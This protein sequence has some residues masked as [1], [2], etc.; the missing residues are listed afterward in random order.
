VFPPGA[1]RCF[2]LTGAPIRWMLLASMDPVPD[3]TRPQDRRPRRRRGPWIAAGLVA[4][5]DLL[6]PVPAASHSAS[7][8]LLGIFKRR[9]GQSASMALRAANQ[10]ARARA[11]RA[12]GISD[13][14]S[15]GDP[16][17]AALEGTEHHTAAGI[18]HIDR[19]H[20]GRRGRNGASSRADAC[21]SISRTMGASWPD[22]GSGRPLRDLHS[23]EGRDSGPKLPL[24]DFRGRNV[25]GGD[26]TLRLR[27]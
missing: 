26:R 6:S 24:A 3:H 2:A 17:L 23:S 7:P 4:L 22:R 27:T 16:T 10:P 18:G 12:S 25:S 13:S 11:W 15:R 1:R 20:P 5:A 19:R 14:T 9:P 21:D 8:S